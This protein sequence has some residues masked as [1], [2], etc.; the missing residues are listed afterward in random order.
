MK[1]MKMNKKPEMKSV[2][3]PTAAT[4]PKANEKEA[5]KDFVNEGNPSTSTPLSVIA[6][7]KK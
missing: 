6:K 5:I 2:K 4:T 1:E 7:N 3:A